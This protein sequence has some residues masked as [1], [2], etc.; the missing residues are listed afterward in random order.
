MPEL[1]VRHETWP[2]R[3]SFAISRGSRTA[4]DVV[5]AEVSHGGFRGRGECVPYARYGET[6]ESVVAAIEG[7]RPALE[8]GLNREA[9]QDRVVAGAARNALDCALWDLSAKQTGRPVWRDAGLATAPE[10]VT[11]AYTLSLDSASAMGTAAAGQADRPLLK[12][13]LAGPEDLDRVAAVHANAPNARLVV[14]AN[15][16]WSLDQ[17]LEFAPRLAE[18]GVAM[19]EQPLPAGEDE[20]LGEIERPVPLCADESCH[21]RAS[22]PALVGRYDL[23]NIKIDKTGGLTEALALKAAAEAAGF[24][25]MVGCRL[26]TSLAMAPALLVAQNVQVV[27]LDGPLLL[28]E[29]REEGLTYQGSLIHPAQPA[30]WG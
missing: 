5:V 23:V 29:D 1:T 12:L 2:I 28:A 24:G 30:L 8:A 10:P 14:D 17:Y 22:L 15:E 26:A 20:P 11:T 21:D 6:I 13:K 27:D 3:G 7:I 9:L 25:I 18:L 19:I 4:V 16:G